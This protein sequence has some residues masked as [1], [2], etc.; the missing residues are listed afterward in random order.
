MPS[1]AAPSRQRHSPHRSDSS[2]PSVVSATRPDACGRLAPRGQR[3]AGRRAGILRIERQQHDLIGLPVPHRLRGLVAQRMPV[4]HGDEALR[5]ELRQLRLQRRRLRAASARAAAIC[6]R[7]WRSSRCAGSSRAAA[8]RRAR[9]GR[10]KNGTRRIAGSVNR[11][12]QKRPDRLRPIG[13]TQVE[14][15]DLPATLGR[16]HLLHQRARHARAASAARCRGP[17]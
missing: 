17:G 9:K 13:P 2:R 15:D 12:Q 8:M 1:A 16:T 6:R 7:A 10:T 11:L 5:V 3:T 4:A 14:Q